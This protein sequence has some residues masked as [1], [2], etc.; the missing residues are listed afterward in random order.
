MDIIKT[1]SERVDIIFDA[2]DDEKVREEYPYEKGWHFKRSGPLVENG[3][4]DI[5]QRHYILEREIE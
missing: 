5:T 3:I 2:V 4:A 1:T